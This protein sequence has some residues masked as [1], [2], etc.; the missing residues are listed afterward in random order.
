[1]SKGLDPIFEGFRTLMTAILTGALH[2]ASKVEVEPDIVVDRRS[3][4]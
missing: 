3:E 2:V 1:M 4:E